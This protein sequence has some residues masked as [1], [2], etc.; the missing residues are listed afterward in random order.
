MSEFQVYPQPIVDVYKE[1]TEAFAWHS[2]GVAAIGVGSVA[3]QMI[4]NGTYT[5]DRL[6]S[7]RVEAYQLGPRVNPEDGRPIRLRQDAARLSD[8]AYGVASV[9]AKACFMPEAEDVKLARL[10]RD[11][12]KSH[13]NNANASA[14]NLPMVDLENFSHSPEANYITNLFR[15]SYDALTSDDVGPAWLRQTIRE[16]VAVVATKTNLDSPA[17]HWSAYRRA[18]D[19]LLEGKGPGSAPERIRQI[20]RA[21]VTLRVYPVYQDVVDRFV[22]GFTNTRQCSFSCL[23]CQAHA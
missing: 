7:D 15:V 13:R 21:A 3:M 22:D 4:S 2:C 18:L 10:R 1:A 16:K 17:E 5:W 12:L 6:L 8:V 14:A 11:E 19:F 23:N 20:I 9:T